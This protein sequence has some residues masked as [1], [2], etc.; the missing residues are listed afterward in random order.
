LTLVGYTRQELAAGAIDLQLLAPLGPGDP[1]CASGV[2][3]PHDRGGSSLEERS[4]VRKDGTSVPTLVGISLLDES[5][6][7]V[8]GFVLDLTVQKHME[9]QRTMLRESQEALRLRELFDSIASHELKTPLTVLTLGLQ[10]LHRR[11]ETETPANTALKLQAERCV[12]SAVRMKDL[13][14]ALLD[15]S[16]V[17]GTRVRLDVREVDLVDAVARIVSAFEVSELCP[18]RQIR[19]RDEGPVTAWLDPLR[20]DQVLTNL[21]SNALKY[22]GREPIEVCV[23]EVRSRDLARVEIVDQGPGIEPAMQELIFQPFR[24]AVQPDGRIPGLGLGLYVVKTIVES[25]GGTISV[26]SQVGHGSRFVV[27]LPRVAR[28][29]A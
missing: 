20:L 2:T 10:M 22:G 19:V 9:A 24:R 18:S 28:S 27:D 8:V 25:H 7:E 13:V 17:H 12:S 6:D 26:E 11:L 4:L 23:S 5:Q 15:V 29:T 14:Q 21:L 16:Q 3:E 1:A